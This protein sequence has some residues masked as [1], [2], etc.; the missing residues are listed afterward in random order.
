MTLLINETCRPHLHNGLT[1][2][3]RILRLENLVEFFERT[4][5]CLNEEEIYY[6]VVVSS[7]LLHVS[8]MCYVRK[9][10]DIPECEKNIELRTF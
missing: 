1:C 4:I 3:S 5:L 10:E 8:V 6:T 2:F 7:L 9:L